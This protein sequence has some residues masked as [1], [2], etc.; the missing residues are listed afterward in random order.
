MP[1]KTFLDPVKGLFRSATGRAAS[2]R[3]RLT[4]SGLG[5]LAS[6]FSD[7]AVA[8]PAPSSAAPLSAATFEPLESRTLMAASPAD[9]P[10]VGVNLD[11]ITY[12]S[13]A[14]TFA[15]AFKQS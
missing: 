6:V 2:S 5:T 11:A 10:Q 13:S 7:D 4:P 3:R 8:A 1:R 15:D 12:Y 9:F 14:W